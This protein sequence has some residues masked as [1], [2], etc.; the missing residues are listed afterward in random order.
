MKTKSGKV[1]YYITLPEWFIK[2]QNV[3]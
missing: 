3:I 2:T 1:V